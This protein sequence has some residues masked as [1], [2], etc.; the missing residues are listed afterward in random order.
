MNKTVQGLKVEIEPIKKAH[1]EGNMEMNN[2]ETQAEAP[3]ASLTN[4]IQ[5]M[6]EKIS[7]MEDAVEEM[8]AL[9]KENVR[10][11][12]LGHC[13]KTKPKNNSNRGRRR[14]PGQRHRK[15]YQQNHEIKFP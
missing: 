2:L 1:A 12:N 8:D 5:E 4:R 3:E 13:E 10:T 11:K 9:V 6:E 15:Y 14:N 7:G